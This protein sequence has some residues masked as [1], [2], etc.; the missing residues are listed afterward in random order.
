LKGIWSKKVGR[1]A[2]DAAGERKMEAAAEN[3]DGT[4]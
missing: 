2:S 3:R 4:T 1:G